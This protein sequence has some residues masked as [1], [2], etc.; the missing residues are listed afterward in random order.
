MNENRWLV[1]SLVMLLAIVVLIFA[2]CQ[3]SGEKIEA[4]SGY[5]L[6]YQNA[7]IQGMPC[8]VVSHFREAAV[9]CDWSKWEGMDALP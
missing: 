8:I 9:S 3:P 7:E 4:K 2:A 6:T 5:R 1:A